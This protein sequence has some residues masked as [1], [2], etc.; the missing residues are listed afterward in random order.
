MTFQFFQIRYDTQFTLEGHSNTIIIYYT[1]RKMNELYPNR[2]YE[3]IGEIGNCSKIY[4]NQ[5]EI[6]TEEG[7]HIPVYPRGSINRP[8]EWIIGYAAVGEKTYV[9]VVKG[10]IPQALISFMQK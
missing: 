10:I 3:V 2:D 7:K 9:A 1:K 5:D 6:L 4:P 8:F